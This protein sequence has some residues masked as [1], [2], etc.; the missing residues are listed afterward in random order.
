MSKALQNTG[1]LH[2]TRG[3]TPHTDL[4]PH[5]RTSIGVALRRGGGSL[6]VRRGRGLQGLQVPA[7][8]FVHFVQRFRIQGIQTRI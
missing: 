6:V 7:V 8:T 3:P 5:T 4:P 1:V 2:S